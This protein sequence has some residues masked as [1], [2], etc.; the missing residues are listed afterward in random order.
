MKI[1]ALR[2]P[3]SIKDDPTR[4]ARDPIIFIGTDKHAYLE[5]AAALG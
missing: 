1:T 4:Y 3:H 2:S 5:K